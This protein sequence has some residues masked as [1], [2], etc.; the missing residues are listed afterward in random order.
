MNL[1]PGVIAQPTL[2][3]DRDRVM[4]NIERMANKAHQSGIRLRPHF[5]THQSAQIGEWFR[6]YTVDAITVSSVDM[7]EYFAKHGWT[8]ITIAF[9]LNWRQI[10]RIDRLAQTITLHLLIECA[11]SAQFL[12]T[13]LRGQASVWID[14]DTGYGRTGTWWEDQHSIEQIVEE[15]KNVSNVAFAGLLTHAGHTYHATATEEIKRIHQ[16]ATD[17][18]IRVRD[19]LGEE[20][21]SPIAISIGD[22]PG[23]S[24]VDDLG[25]VDEIRP[26]NFVFYDVKQ[27]QLGAC[28][29]D[30]IA[31]AVAC[32]VVAKYGRRREIVIYGG[33]VHLSKDWIV[34]EGGRR[35]FG[36]PA[37]WTESGW[38]PAI[39]DGVVSS[40]SQEVGVVKASKG[41]FQTS[42]VGDLLAVLPIHSCLTVSAM[43][44]YITLDGA[45]IDCMAD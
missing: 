15:V 29:P 18:M 17:R 43:K 7:A 27:W 20:C 11:E 13:Q 22:T 28:T 41:L 12:A 16:E 44:H 24:V 32:P 14:I 34:D 26:G 25:E 37:R 39:D 36:Y 9:P 33:A 2:L 21:D 4:R 6:P 31:I 35:V 30:D 42:R 3:I 10:E 23:C 5:K 1:D 8:D 19:A 38:D 40:L 45:R